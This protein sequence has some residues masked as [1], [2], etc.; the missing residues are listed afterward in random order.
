M[1]FASFPFAE[2]PWRKLGEA[3]FELGRLD[4]AIAAFEESPE[5]AAQVALAA[6][7]GLAPAHRDVELCGLSVRALSAGEGTLWERTL[8]ELCGRPVEGA[9]LAGRSADLA[10]VEVLVEGAVLLLAIDE[11]EGRLRWTAELF[12][13]PRGVAFGQRYASDSRRLLV[14]SLAYAYFT[15]GEELKRVPRCGFLYALEARTGRLLWF[16]EVAVRSLA[17]FEGFMKRADESIDLAVDDV[18]RVS[19][20]GGP[21]WKFD[22]RTGRALDRP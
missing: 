5:P 15:D 16:R 22:S 14:A 1:A 11:E 17:V 10:L 19:F 7:R 18:V 8:T 21:V 9:R 12:I 20:G 13:G 6:A 4:D 3:Y 2:R